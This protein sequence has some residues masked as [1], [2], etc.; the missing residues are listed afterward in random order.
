MN[1]DQAIC[2][3][4]AKNYIAAART[5][6]KSFL[7]YHP[8]YKCYVLIVDEFGDYINPSEECFEV[9]TMADI[10]IPNLP[11][12][13]F[14]YNI[15]ELCTASKPFLMEYL[16]EQKSL[17]KLLYIDPDIFITNKL[18][19]IFN[20]LDHHDIVL[21]PHL[22]TDYPDDKL[23]PNDGWILSSGIFN[24]GF[25][26][27]NS[28]QNSRSFLDWWKIKLYNKC[29]ADPAQGYFVDQKF[30]DFVPTFF[31]NIFIEKDVGYNVAY[32]NLHSRSLRRNGR[33]WECNNGPLYFYHFSNY[34]PDKPDVISGYLTRYR[35]SDRGDLQELFSEYRTKLLENGQ[36]EA[37]KWP[38]TYAS[39]VTGETIPKELRI[40]YRN[41]IEQWDKYGNPFESTELKR[42]AVVIKLQN[43]N[44]AS[45]LMTS[46]VYKYGYGLR[47]IYRRWVNY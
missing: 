44:A 20:R 7:T 21:T 15:V 23:M 35:L 22:D 25:I 14:K 17:R 42:R 12:F 28:S 40:L 36:Q 19:K 41:F 10:G 45:F 33:F 11:S 27:I 2:T 13:C 3:I 6:C 43:K 1:Q 38:Y 4:I 9:V 18:D 29:I 30:I 8:D 34:N 16:L 32:W 39:F 47:H 31:E 37:S 26:G 46:L 5:L 24:L